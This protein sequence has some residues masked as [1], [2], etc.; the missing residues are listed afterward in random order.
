MVTHKNNAL[1]VKAWNE[2]NPELHKE[3]CATYA[4]NYAL[5]DP[6]KYAL[7]NRLSTAKYYLWKRTVNEL[8]NI[9][10]TLFL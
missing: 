9:D 4:K 5:R 3:R 1:Y 2:R 8:I 7:N 10:P 6:E